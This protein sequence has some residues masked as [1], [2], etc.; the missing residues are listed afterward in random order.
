AILLRPETNHTGLLGLL[1]NPIE[2]LLQWVI[3][4]Y[5]RIVTFVVRIRYV[6]LLFFFGALAATA[7]MYNHVPTAFIPQEDQSYFLIIVQTPPGASLGYTTEFADRVAAVVQK[8]D[9]VFGT[10]SVMG[11]SLAGGS[12]P[13]SGLIFAPLKPVDDRTKLGK[14]HTAHDIVARIAPKLFGVPGGILYAVEP[15]AIQGIG[16]VGG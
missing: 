7:F 12:S 3:R 4:T 16:T 5:G 9:G 11:F 1:L 10:F 2:R 13:N 15:P 14:G 8:N 6:M